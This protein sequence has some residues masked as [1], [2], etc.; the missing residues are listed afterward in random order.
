MTT[1][2]A[3]PGFWT[4]LHETY[5]R[6]YVIFGALAVP[7]GCWILREREARPLSVPSVYL[8]ALY[9]V[10][11]RVEIHIEDLQRAVKLPTWRWGRVV[12]QPD[13]RQ[14]LTGYH[15]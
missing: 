11:A 5:W 10:N 3:A 12:A 13:E 9:H 14:R 2:G 7:A 1:H 15:L 8:F 4:E 6:L